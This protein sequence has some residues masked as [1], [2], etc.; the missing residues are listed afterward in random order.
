MKEGLEQEIH[1]GPSKPTLLPKHKHAYREAFIKRV[2][3]H[4]YRFG[5]LA[6]ECEI[7]VDQGETANGTSSSSVQL[8]G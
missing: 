6:V 4:A 5:T 3:H 2:L 8:E 1:A 7:Q